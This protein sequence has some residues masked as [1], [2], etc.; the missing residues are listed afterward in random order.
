M[1][2]QAG[3]DSLGAVELRNAISAEFGMDVPATLAFDYPTLA[4]LASFVA[5]SRPSVER[6]A[7][8]ALPLD[9]EQSAADTRMAAAD[10]LAGVRRVALAVLGTAV[11]DDQPLMEVECRSSGA[12]GMSDCPKN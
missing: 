4:A 7:E 8:A 5:A 9:A 12:L 2:L 3:L 6:I 10:V 11:P 1:V